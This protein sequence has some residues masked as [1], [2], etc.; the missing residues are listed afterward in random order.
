[1]KKYQFL[2]FIFLIF[3]FFL[4]SL[5]ILQREIFQPGLILATTTSLY[6]SGLLEPLLEAFKRQSGIRV[7]AIAVGTG[8]ALKMGQK[9]EADFLLVHAP[10][11]EEEFMAAGYGLKR[12]ELMSS[13][14]VIAGPKNDPAEIRGLS[15]PEAFSRIARIKAAFISRADYSGTHFL[16]R[17][18][19]EEAGLSPSGKWYHETQQGMA[20][21]MM[22]AA[23]KRAYILADYPTYYRLK[24]RH[25]LEDL[26]SDENYLNIY[27]A[28]IPLSSR[29]MGN[30]KKARMLLAFL[31]S[32]KVKE[33][34]ISFGYESQGQPPFFYLLNLAALAWNRRFKK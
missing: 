27:S 16:E 12:Q 34:I 11:L 17:K 8:E 31:L 30:E 7:K 5:S 18:I 21:A 20:E 28:I 4:H 1:M 9:G 32:P 10:K 3:L 24:K 29:Q 14:V 6:D 23:E 19:W 26:T 15:F 13:R 2:F 33:I 22:I 25:N